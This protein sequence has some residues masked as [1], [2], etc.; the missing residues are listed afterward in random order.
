VTNRSVNCL[1][2]AVGCLRI[3]AEPKTSVC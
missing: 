1:S 3:G 2:T